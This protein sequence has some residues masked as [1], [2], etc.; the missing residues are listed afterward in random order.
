MKRL[1]GMLLL[2]TLVLVGCGEAD[3]PPGK[4]SPT[5]EESVSALETL[6]AKVKRNEQDG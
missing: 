1:M 2:L 3:A 4:S 6:G 5:T